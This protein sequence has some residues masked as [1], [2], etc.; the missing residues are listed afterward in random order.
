IVL[1]EAAT[2]PVRSECVRKT[3]E[4]IAGLMKC[5][6]RSASNHDV[7]LVTKRS[8]AVLEGDTVD[9]ALAPASALGLL[10]Q[11]ECDRL[12]VRSIDFEDSDALAI[13]EAVLAEV[14]AQ[15]AGDIAYR[16]GK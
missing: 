4:A 10:A 7:T 3:S 1:L 8:K 14:A 16:A 5:L 15:S 11:N 6:V 9:A 2:D 13:A 12:A